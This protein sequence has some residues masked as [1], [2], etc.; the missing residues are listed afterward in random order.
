[1]PATFRLITAADEAQVVAIYNQAI[2]TKGSTADLT[3]LTVAQ[4]QPWFQEFSP[5]HFPLWVIETTAG[6]VGYVGLEPYSDRQAYAQTA[7]IAI[8]LSADAQ[9]QHLGTQAL[10]WVESQTPAL[11]VTT[12]ISRIFGHNQA[13]RHL[14][15]KFGY[16]HWGHLP[17][18]ADM[19]GFI[20]DLEVY[21]KHLS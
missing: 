12:I 19:Q 9:G 6:I 16:E 18:I 7:E 4:R 8:Y 21:G 20:A 11:K 2:A 1:M 15:E 17:E 3:P 13:S 10:N 5:D 14:F